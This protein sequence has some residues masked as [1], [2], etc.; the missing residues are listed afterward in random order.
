MD[1][2]MDIQTDGVWK[3]KMEQNAVGSTDDVGKRERKDGEDLAESCGCG[4]GWSVNCYR[5]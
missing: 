5:A 1:G 3:T 4:N 2:W